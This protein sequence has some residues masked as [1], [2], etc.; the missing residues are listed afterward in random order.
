MLSQRDSDTVFSSVSRRNS[1]EADSSVASEALRPSLLLCLAAAASASFT[2]GSFFHDSASTI[3]TSVCCAL[4]LFLLPLQTGLF[5]RA[6]LLRLFIYTAICA[7]GGFAV[8]QRA[9][10]FLQTPVIP[11][12]D[13]WTAEVTEATPYRYRDR[14]ILRLHPADGT[15]VSVCAAAWTPKSPPFRE[16]DVIAL[17]GT[18][19]PLEPSASAGLM[20]QGIRFSVRLNEGTWTFLSRAAPSLR[21]RFRDKLV[22]RNMNLYGEKNGGVIN[23]LMLGDSYFVDKTT[24]YEFTRAG[25]LH[26]LAASGTHVAII[27]AIPLFLLPLLRIP[28]KAIYLATSAIL[29]LYF[30][31]TCMPVSLLRACLMFWAI[32]AVQIAG[33]K[34]DTL[35]ALYLSAAAIL[36]L[37]PHEL[38]SLGFQ[39]S[40]GATFGVILFLRRFRSALPRLPFKISESIAMTLAAQIA[41]LPILCCSI[42]ELNLTGLL[43][44]IV[45]VPGMG[46]ALLG[47]IAC[48]SLSL[49]SASAGTFAA[50]WISL[51]MDGTLFAAN[52]AA[53]LPGHFLLPEA[54]LW[55]FIPYLALCVPLILRKTRPAVAG[56]C[57]AAAVCGSFIPLTL[58]KPGASA[59]LSVLEKNPQR[60]LYRDGEKALLRG[61]VRTPQERDTIRT[62]IRSGGYCIA[63]LYMDDFSPASLKETAALVKNTPIREVVLA[64]GVPIDGRIMPL[65]EALDTDGISPVFERRAKNS[66]QHAPTV[67]PMKERCE[68]ALKDAQKPMEG[69]PRTAIRYL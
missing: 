51:F 3:I 26:I 67:Y 48:D 23:A 21:S 54:P 40:Y 6:S 65:L 38:Y 60:A 43:S 46:L 27:A 2:Y 5:S 58:S 63:S 34:G 35:N 55:L 13:A 42:G 8:H 15:P 62:S 22:A 37:H 14:L 59:E 7:A 44:N 69:R 33:R 29:L 53:R 12:S 50:H 18:P 66:C 30:Y 45:L 61:G 17:C 11:A 57:I 28:K 41:V 1:D 49:L 39:L 36:I 64:E 47:S 20:R 31:M 19:Q 68:A 56:A 25:V 24:T 4:F 52:Q 9:S 10:Y 16:G 32:S